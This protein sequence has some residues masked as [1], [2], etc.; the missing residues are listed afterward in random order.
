MNKKHFCS[1]KDLNCKLNPHNHDYGCD[2][3]VK[4]CFL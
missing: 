1:C 2:P 4:K 3:C